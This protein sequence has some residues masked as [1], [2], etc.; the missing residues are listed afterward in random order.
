MNKIT[1]DTTGWVNGRTPLNQ[2][3]MNK[4]E[5][6]LQAIAD[7]V[8]EI[9]DFVD[10]SEPFPS[11]KGRI[12]SVGLPSAYVQL[13]YV[14]ADG[15]QYV[16]TGYKIASKKM[17]VVAHLGLDDNPASMSLFGSNAGSNYNLVVYAGN[18]SGNFSVWV[19]SSS[20]IL[21]REYILGYNE[22]EYELDNGTIKA[23][24]NGIVSSGSYTGSITTNRNFYIFGK[25]GNGSSQ[26]RGRGYRLYSF[27]LYDDGVLVRDYVPC[28]RK[29][30]GVVGLYDLCQGTFTDSA[31]SVA[32]L[33]GGEESYSSPLATIR[34]VC[35][36]IEF[37]E[38]PSIEIIDMT[39]AN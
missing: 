8:N 6:N 15:T 12:T 11:R 25:N 31:T 36:Y 30:D 37:K 19:G 21:T 14:K 20:G 22:I 28:K 38:K 1:I 23:N 34:D 5:N 10:D 35:N 39:E 4:I 24:I 7:K 33:G 13:S 27:R 32:L 2:T 17:K 18:E 3:N 16:D 9:V 29:S 26:E